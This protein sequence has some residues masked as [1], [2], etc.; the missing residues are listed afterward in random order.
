MKLALTHEKDHKE[1]GNYSNIQH[2]ECIIKELNSG[3]VNDAT[4]LYKNGLAS[5]A[6]NLLNLAITEDKATDEQIEEKVNKWNQALID[7]KLDNLYAELTYDKVNK[8]VHTL[9]LQ[10]RQAHFM[11]Q[12]VVKP[13]SN[14][15]NDK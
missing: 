12:P 5:Y 7:N 11:I 2:V 10:P 8:K 6:G 15:Y 3:F 1:N 9:L 4:N 13:I 14:Y